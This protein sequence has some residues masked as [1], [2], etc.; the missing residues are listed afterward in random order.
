MTSSSERIALPTNIEHPIIHEHIHTYEDIHPIP[1]IKSPRNG[2]SLQKS[3]P[4]L[5]FGL[6]FTVPFVSLSTDKILGLGT[7][8]NHDSV[9]SLF[10]L[11][12]SGLILAAVVGI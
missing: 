7:G 5:Q 11:N 12:F 3:P 8:K 6:A 10:K 1:H 9:S 4:D 2:I